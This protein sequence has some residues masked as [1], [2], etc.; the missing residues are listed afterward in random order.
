MTHAEEV[1]ARRCTPIQESPVSAHLTDRCDESKQSSEQYLPRFLSVRNESNS[2][3]SLSVGAQAVASIGPIPTW[4]EKS[5][6]PEASCRLKEEALVRGAVLD[7]QEPPQSSNHNSLK[8]EVNCGIPPDVQHLQADIAVDL[9]SSWIITTRRIVAAEDRALG[10]LTTYR[11]TSEIN[12]LVCG[13]LHHAMLRPSL[14]EQI[15]FIAVHAAV[16]VNMY[17]ERQRFLVSELEQQAGRLKAM[18][19]EEAARGPLSALFLLWIEPNLNKGKSTVARDKVEGS[20]TTLVPARPLKPYCIDRTRVGSTPPIGC[21]V[22]VQDGCSTT[23]TAKR[24]KEEEVQHTPSPPRATDTCTSVALRRRV[25][26]PRSTTN[27]GST[28]NLVML[29]QRF[30]DV[31]AQPGTLAMLAQLPQS[32]RGGGTST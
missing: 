31:V 28:R 32:R 14:Q 24:N 19:L 6:R 10:R 3:V 25:Q 30:D 9:F 29:L 2:S 1:P 22:K 11:N 12:M 13:E 5:S 7:P 16:R 15:Y 20:T 4:R 26:P 23:H 27:D 21:I 17:S 8:H 18:S